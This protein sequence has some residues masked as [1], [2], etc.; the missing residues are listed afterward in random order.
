MKKIN[1]KKNKIYMIYTAIFCI[2]SFI[3]FAV[4]IKN[5]KSFIWH[6]DG[7]KQHY[8]ILYDFNQIVRNLFENG[9]SM[10][11]WDMGLGMDMIG[12]YSYYVL[13]DPFAYISLLFPMNW[14]EAVY[15]ILIILRIYCVGLAFIAY[16]RYQKKDG[17]SVLIGAICYTFCGFILYAG[18][19]HPYFTNA[20]ILLP[21]TFIAIEKLLR[22]NKKSF[23][24]FMVFVSAISNYYFFYMITMINIIYAVIKYIFEYNQGIKDFFKKVL[25]A[26]LCYLIGIAMASIVLLPTIYAFLNSARIGYEQTYLYSPNFY[27]FFFMGFIC[28]RHCNWTII[29]ISSI[30][31][32]MVPVLFTKLKEKEF[33]T[34]AS[35]FVVTTI[36]LL[37]PLVSSIMNGLSFPSNRWSFAYE[38]ILA[39]IIT[40]CFENHLKYSKRQIIAM[41]IFLAIYTVIGMCI[42]KVKIGANL[43][44]YVAI[45]MA[46]LIWLIILL[47]HIKDKMPKKVESL[48]KYSSII[49]T[50]LVICSI[51]S[52]SF[53]LYSK[54]GKGY[55][56]EFINNKS[57]IKSND[58]LN[59][60]MMN[61]KE[62]ID[63]IK[64][65]D[66]DFYRIAKS[67]ISQQNTSLLFDYHSI[68]T[69]L[70]IGNGY[71]YNFS[72]G[73]E[74]NHCTTTRC[75]NGI[76]RRTQA[77]TL[78]GTK[79]YIC[80]KNNIAYV[81]YGYKLYHEIEDTKIY[82]NE[83]YL[84]PGIFYDSYILEE[85]YDKLSPLQKEQALLTTAVLKEDTN[86]TKKEDLTDKINH[87]DKITYKEKGSLIQ[88]NKIDVTKNNE[89]VYLQ[90]DNMKPDTEVYLSIK[91]L[92]YNSK[93]KKK[94]YK[95]TVSFNGVKDDEKVEDR[96]SSAYYEKNPDFLINLGIIKENTNNEIQISFSRKGTYSFDEIEILAVPMNQYEEKAKKLKKNEMTD[97]VYGNDYI[98]GQI[99]NKADGIL[100]ITT[101]YSSGWKAFVDGEETEIIKV[102]K[103]FVGIFIPE[104]NHKVD[105][106]YETP[107]LKLAFVLSVLGFII[108][109][110]VFIWERRKKHQNIIETK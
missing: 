101:S 31:L 7:L 108:F 79:Y 41:G 34:Y 96:I 4:F 71:V 16:C 18:V 3:I 39:Y 93:S 77:M 109:I 72:R 61:F 89:S 75:I 110:G 22:E 100:Q 91:N 48:F 45:M 88:N 52:S 32:L 23:L 12:Q 27:Q 103:G 53:A 50:I 65:N 25:T 67:D 86:K 51:W 95:V 60:K 94:D 68:Q 11:S 82:I 35:L 59:G 81:P 63:Y 58:T 57:V 64:Q 55:A 62:A 84:S 49:V 90:L 1:I 24:I 78:L 80:S 19:R 21:L 26:G 70:S 30:I 105:F 38:F 74:D 2:V 54:S 10:L 33:K 85:E 83:Y 36:M 46:S 66:K 14:L 107:Y 29:C 106:K 69:Y 56:A 20:A 47:N 98:S 76:N 104:G 99:K 13:G 28:M 102:N 73:L 15:S 40:I 8:V 87:I 6:S 37:I 42:T 97:I 5:G 17:I 92:K 43:D 44:F 9:F